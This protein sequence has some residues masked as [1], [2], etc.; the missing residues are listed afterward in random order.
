MS[1][2]QLGKE[3]AEGAEKKAECSPTCVMNHSQLKS[4]SCLVLHGPVC[5]SKAT[6]HPRW[7]SLPTSHNLPPGK[8]LRLLGLS[9]ITQDN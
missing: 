6:A 3:S 9:S 8:S 4:L 2:R 7:P 1:T 5:L